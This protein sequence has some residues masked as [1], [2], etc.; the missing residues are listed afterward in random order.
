MKATFAKWIDDT[1]YV[2]TF[3]QM[4]TWVNDAGIDRSKGVPYPTE[5]V[6]LSFQPSK[7]Q[8]YPMVQKLY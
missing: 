8:L 5:K 6:S 2:L 3:C 7:Q 1:P 4:K